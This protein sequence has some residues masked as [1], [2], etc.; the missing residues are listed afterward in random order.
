MR[1]ILHKNI[2]LKSWPILKWPSKLL[3]TAGAKL[4]GRG[5]ATIFKMERV[6]DIVR[7]YDGDSNPIGKA[8]ST[9][10]FC[11]LVEPYFKI[12]KIY[13]HF[14][15]A[16]SLPFPVPSKLHRLLDKQAGFLIYLNLRKL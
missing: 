8:Y 9:S 1:E 11:A 10:E 15:P 7:M 14:F 5:R 6:E 16:R 2:F 3:A 12:E 4:K 13:F